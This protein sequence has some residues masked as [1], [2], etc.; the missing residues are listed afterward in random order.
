MPVWQPEEFAAAPEEFAAAPA[1]VLALAN[2]YDGIDLPD[3]A[4]RLVIIAGLPVSM[5]LQERFLHESA[6]AG[7]GS[8][9][10]VPASHYEGLR[11]WCRDSAAEPFSSRHARKT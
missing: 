7:T 9:R 5:H 6:R 4:C 11:I 2:R 3:E 10:P 8:P 1:G